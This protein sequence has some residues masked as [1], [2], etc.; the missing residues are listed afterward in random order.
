MPLLRWAGAFWTSLGR[1]AALQ[2][3]QQLHGC[4]PLLTAVRGQQRE[5]A[6]L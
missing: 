4:M 5:A 1:G 6:R 2:E 3:Q